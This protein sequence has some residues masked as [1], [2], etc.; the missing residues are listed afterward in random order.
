MKNK[1]FLFGGVTLLLAVLA[2]ICIKNGNNVVDSIYNSNVEAL[3]Q[4]ESLDKCKG[5]ST[6]GEIYCCHLIILD[7]G[8]FLLYRD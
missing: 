5:C 3:A 6:D 8:G 7:V 1:F 4:N 2:S